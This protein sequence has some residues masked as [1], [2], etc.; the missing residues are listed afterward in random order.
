[1]KTYSKCG[2]A[3][4]LVFAASGYAHSAVIEG[5]LFNTGLDG[6]GNLISGT[7][8]DANWETKVP[9]GDAVA[10]YN[11]AYAANDAD[12]QWISIATDGASNDTDFRETVFS[13]TFDLTGYDA[14]TAMIT[15][16]WGVDNYATIFLNGNDTSVALPFGTSS[17]NTL[18]N[19]DISDFFVDGL[20]TLTVDVTNGYFPDTDRTDIGPLALRFDD[21]VL[22]AT[23]VPEP[24]TLALL[25]LG[26]AALGLTRRKK[27]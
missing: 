3:I 16:A 17:F 8:I 4:A 10:Y 6:S 23:K 24:G 15:G 25:G 21:L 1:M 18:A 26:L 13:T 22:T 27:A 12:S 5:Q 19:F 9:E 7:Q 14:S 2:M 20:N 11:G